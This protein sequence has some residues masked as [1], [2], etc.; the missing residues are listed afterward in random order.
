MKYTKIIVN[1]VVAL[2]ISIGI[3]TAQSTNEPIK[4]TLTPLTSTNTLTKTPVIPESIWRFS[5]AGFGNDNVTTPASTQNKNVYGAEI[6]LSHDINIVLP[7]YIGIRQDLGYSQS[8]VNRVV[9]VSSPVPPCCSL[10]G[11]DNVSTVKSFDKDGYQ[12]ATKVFY[13]WQLLRIGNLA[14]DGGANFGVYYGEQ[15]LNLQVSPEFDTRIFLWKNTD[16]FGRVEYPYDINSGQFA[17]SIKYTAGIR[18][19]F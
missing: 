10:D 12:A 19:G 14:F 15:D 3:T 6:E 16:I 2:M 11:K 17:G 9:N 18:I 8:T 4:S 5:L 13:D 7:G 1:T